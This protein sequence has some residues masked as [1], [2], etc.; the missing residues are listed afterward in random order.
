MPHFQTI[1]DL[2]SLRS[3]GFEALA[4][5]TD[6]D[7]GCVS[8][9]LFIP[10]A[11][12]RSIIGRLSQLVLCKTAE[13]ARSWLKDMFLSLNL[14]QSQLVDQNIGLRIL[15]ILEPSG[16]DLRRL[17]IIEAYL[18]TDHDSAKK[19]VEDL[20][21]VSIRVSLDNFDTGPSPFGRLHEFCRLYPQPA[22]R[23]VDFGEGKADTIAHGL[24][25]G[26]LFAISFYRKYEKYI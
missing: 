2:N 4:R 12:E 25:A 24:L 23:V 9:A 1:V 17:E 18:M 21:C 13:A 14:F 7:L 11:E 10:I 8:L 3:I 5:W 15:L 20:R 26:I 6:H 16:L 22:K 19:I